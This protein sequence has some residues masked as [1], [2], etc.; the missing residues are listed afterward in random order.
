[1]DKEQRNMFYWNIVKF[2]VG[3]A[4]LSISYW[5]I[6]NHPAERVSIMSG[7][8]VMYEKWQLFVYDLLWKDTTVLRQKHRLDQYYQEI[9]RVAEHKWC[10]APDL[11]RDIHETYNTFSHLTLEELWGYLQYYSAQAVEF[12]AAVQES[13]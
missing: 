6:Q 12:D 7:F 8:S 2:V 3:I 5:Y 1:M 9:I 13:C 4:L 10:T 11:L